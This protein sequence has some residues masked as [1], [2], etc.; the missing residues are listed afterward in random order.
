MYNIII[1][2]VELINIL[3]TNRIDDILKKQGIKN[4]DDNYSDEFKYRYDFE[5]KKYLLGKYYNWKLP[6]N[7]I[8]IVDKMFY[9]LIDKDLFKLSYKIIF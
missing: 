7:Y 8:S 1:N 9:T 4:T 5:L 6:S 3:D 2:T